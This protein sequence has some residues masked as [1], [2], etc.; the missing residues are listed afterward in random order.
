MDFKPYSKEYQLRS[1][2]KRKD[3][4]KPTE[5]RPKK[6]RKKLEVVKGRA[7]PPSKVRGSISKKEYEKAIDAFGS[8][9][10]ICMDP[11]I[12]MH[13]L[14]FRSH[15]GRG[16][17]RNLIP[18]CNKHHGL[19]HTNKN[20]A[21]SLREERMERYGEWYWCDKFD[22]LKAGLIVNSTDEEFEKWMIKEEVKAS[23]TVRDH[24][25]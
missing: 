12:E 19:A 25:N 22:L 15:Q 14:R 4:P 17:Y 13:H 21:D 3:K 7:I 10:A 16:N 2:Q 6:K 20:F 11:H 5:K 8:N 1:S 9:C 18:L 24:K 23:E